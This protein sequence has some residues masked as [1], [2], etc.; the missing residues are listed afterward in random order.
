VNLVI[1]ELTEAMFSPRQDRG[2]KSPAF[3]PAR[4][5]KDLTSALSS[6]CSSPR[7]DDIPLTET[8]EIKRIKASL[9]NE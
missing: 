7:H 2:R 9:K 8:K 1:Y 3:Q 4:D 5:I 6:I